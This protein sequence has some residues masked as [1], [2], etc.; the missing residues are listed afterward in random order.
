LRGRYYWFSGG[1]T[2]A[3]HDQATR[4]A[5]EYFKRAVALQPDYA[6]A[7]SGLSDFYEVS[8]LHGDAPPSD[9]APQARAAAIEALRLDGALADA[10][11]SMAASYLFFTW[12][13]Q[14]ALL[15]A[16]RAVELGPNIAEYHYFRSRILITLNRMQDALEEEKKANELD[17][18]VRPFAMG[19]ML[20]SMRRYDEAV[21]E[22]RMRLETLPADARLH[23][24]LA[25]AY[26]RKGMKQDAGLELEKAAL[27]TSDKPGEAAI[28]NAFEKGGYEGIIRLQLNAM[29]SKAQRDYVSPLLLADQYAQLGLKEQTIHLLEEGYKERSPR[30]VWLQSWPAYDFLHSDQRYQNIV[31]QMGLP[32]AF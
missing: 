14:Q 26:W 12:D 24:R 6:L 11:N 3:L 25:E 17:P 29:N 13:W 19:Y 32:P 31:R 9:N 2:D 15:H 27:L 1:G 30:L 23:Q 10:H 4:K 7:W 16:N 18:F 28:R 8:T 5:G 21:N 20:Y 22:L